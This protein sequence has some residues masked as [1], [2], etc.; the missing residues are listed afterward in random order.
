MLDP[1][2]TWDLAELEYALGRVIAIVYWRGVLSVPRRIL[3]R[4]LILVCSEPSSDRQ[5]ADIQLQ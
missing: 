2:F 4:L 1:H 5:A 3:Y